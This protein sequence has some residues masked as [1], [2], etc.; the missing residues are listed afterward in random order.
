LQRYVWLLAVRH[1]AR[2]QRDIW[3]LARANLAGRCTVIVTA[4]HTPIIKPRQPL[5][6]IVHEALPRPL[7]ERDIL[8]VTSKVISLEQGRLVDLETVQVSARAREMLAAPHEP[9]EGSQPSQGSCGAHPLHPGLAELVL[10]E[11]EIAYAGEPVWLSLKDG[12]FVANAGIDLSNAPAGHAI[13]WPDRPWE[14]ACD[15]RQRLRQVYKIAELGVII[16]DSRCIPLRR[17]VTGVAMAFCGFEGVES[18]KGKPDIFGRPLQFTEKSVADDLATAAVLVGG[19]AGEQTPFVLIEGAPA[20]FTEQRFGPA[21]VL[22]DPCIDMFRPLYSDE[23]NQRIMEV[24]HEAT[25]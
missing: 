6:P 19:E 8:C 10:Q 12:L 20:V 2:L 9:C 13:L 17:G 11:S 5:L 1:L 21:D 16:T 24:G 15:F 25:G 23:F 7:R 22:V 3:L 4:I 14:W 18:Q